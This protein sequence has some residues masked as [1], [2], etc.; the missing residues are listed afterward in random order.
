MTDIVVHP[1]E[2]ADC[3]QKIGTL[4]AQS[5]SLNNQATKAAVPEISW[6]ALGHL[7]GLYG[8]Y[9]TLL[10]ELHS[11]Y[12]AMSTGF[13]KISAALSETAKSYHDSDHTSA[14]KFNRLLGTS[15]DHAR[16]PSATITAA[17]SPQSNLGAV[18]SSYGNQWAIDGGKGNLVSKTAG[19]IPIVNGSYLLIKDSIQLGTDIKSGNAEVIGKDVVGVLADMN[20][21]VQDGVALAG[22]I[23]D[24]LN[25]LISKGLGWLLN[26]VAP[27]KQMIDLV[28]GDPAATSTAAG[29]FNG[30]A[31][32]TE[33]L[34]KSY[35]DHLRNGLRTWNSKAADAAS[36]KL[37]GFHNGIE[38]TAS[39]AGHVAAL[40]QGSS[41]LMQA[42]EDVIKGILSDL[43]EWLVVTWVA[44]QLAAVPTAGASEAVAAAATPVEA[45][46]ST[47]KAAGEVNKIRQ[48]LTRIM[49]V[50]RKVRDLLRASKIGKTFVKNVSEA[51]KEGKMA[52]TLS[53]AITKSVEKNAGKVLP[54][55]GKDAGGDPMKSIDK[56]AQA[57]KTYA[58]YADGVY[59]TVDYGLHGNQQDDGTINRELGV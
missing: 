33:Q 42:A 32:Q 12:T 37:A 16:A 38:G 39:T 25:F 55:F 50:L 18:G 19:S 51:Q 34:A 45:G 9:A 4:T 23:A 46:I 1:A 13:D 30:I 35:D 43:I 20:T 15:L 59:K 49:E 14:D 31:Q 36:V 11:H 10:D 48:L 21:Y 53:D 57:G 7:M 40:L 29:T 27:L 3:A 44:A 24:P 54:G 52:K 58:G 2:I 26:V 8:Q 28:T 22:A 41:M 6:G 5:S 47:A 17:A 56:N